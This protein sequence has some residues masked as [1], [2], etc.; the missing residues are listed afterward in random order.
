MNPAQ[1]D[2][3]RVLLH[4]VLLA[5]V[6]A[7]IFETAKPT[8]AFLKGARMRFPVFEAMDS[9]NEEAREGGNE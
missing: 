2:Q 5:E 7:K 9:E 8:R 6:A 4:V 1:P 3:T